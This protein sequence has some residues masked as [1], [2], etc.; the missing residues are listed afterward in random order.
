MRLKYRVDLILASLP[1][2]YL[3]DQRFELTLLIIGQIFSR[4]DD[5]F[6][7]CIMKG[8]FFGFRG[9]SF[10]SILSLFPIHSILPT[11]PHRI[12]SLEIRNLAS[13]FEEEYA[14]SDLIDEISIM[15]DHDQTSLIRNQEVL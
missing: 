6:S 10:H 7:F 3:I 8:Y 5:R 11:Y 9:M 4:R 12:S 13:T 1:R 14:I 15:R 2:R